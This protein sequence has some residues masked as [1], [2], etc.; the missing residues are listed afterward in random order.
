MLYLNLY[1]CL[2]NSCKNIC[3]FFAVK[4]GLAEETGDTI[5]QRRPWRYD[6]NHT[7]VVKLL[8]SQ[9]C[10]HNAAEATCRQFS[11][12]S[13]HPS[14]DTVR[15]MELRSDSRDSGLGKESEIDCDRFL[16]LQNE[17]V[18]FGAHGRGGTN[19][20]RAFANCLP[21]M[22]DALSWQPALHLQTDDSSDGRHSEISDRKTCN[23]IPLGDGIPEDP[24]QWPLP[25]SMFPD[26]NRSRLPSLS[27]FGR[28]P[29]SEHLLSEF[30]L[31]Q[32]EMLG[33][34]DGRGDL[35]RY[36]RGNGLG[37]YSQVDRPADYSETNCH[38]NWT[39]G[40]SAALSAA[41]SFQSTNAMSLGAEHFAKSKPF[42]AVRWPSYLASKGRY[43]Q[44]QQFITTEDMQPDCLRTSCPAPNSRLGL[45]PC[46]SPSYFNPPHSY[47]FYS[48]CTV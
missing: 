32:K 33:I 7:A 41:K 36:R 40:R 44:K 6:R 27:T 23:R 42:D 17:H 22:E 15:Q 29:P 26:S 19:S 2:Y 12:N 34:H 9:G 48:E 4:P 10:F 21:S 16:M 14:V 46:F 5:E 13:L 39:D 8:E 20:P 28:S 38:Q 45:E 37:N 1:A 31:S 24:D 35:D 11:R 3:K 18:V 25:Y 47:H 43:N 30:R